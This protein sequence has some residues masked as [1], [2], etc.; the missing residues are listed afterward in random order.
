VHEIEGNTRTALAELRIDRE[1]LGTV[2]ETV[3]RADSYY[4]VRVAGNLDF[5]STPA[6]EYALL[7]L[8][9]RPGARVTLD[10]ADV[11]AIDS[12]ALGVVLRAAKRLW[13]TLG[14]LDVVSPAGSV[15][16]TLMITGLD[17]LIRVHD[18]VDAVGDGDG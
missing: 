14:E 5:A 7:P 8:S 10:L 4:V 15:R 6:L 12:T 3:E 16:R 11:E 13:S 17:R 18:G 2:V 9:E 1:R